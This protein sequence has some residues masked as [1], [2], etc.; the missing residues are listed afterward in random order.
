MGI[1]KAKG[2]SV[3]LPPAAEYF[4]RGTIFMTAAT[5][6]VFPTLE[7]LFVPNDIYRYGGINATIYVTRTV[8]CGSCGFVFSVASLVYGYQLCTALKGIL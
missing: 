2:K 4:K 5:T 6:L 7:V 1:I 8:L 3:V